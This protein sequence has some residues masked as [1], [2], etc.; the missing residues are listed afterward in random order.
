MDVPP[1]LWPATVTRRGSPPNV[2]ML[3]RTHCSAACWSRRPVAEGIGGGGGGNTSCC[4]CGGGR[5]MDDG[6]GGFV[7]VL[8]LDAFCR[9]HAGT[10][11]VIAH[12]TAILLQRCNSKPSKYIEPVVDRH[13]DATCTGA[14]MQGKRSLILE[15]PTA[16]HERPAVD[17]DENRQGGGG[18]GEG[19]GGGPDVEVKTVFAAPTA[20]HASQ[21]ATQASDM[22]APRLHARVSVSRGV[23]NTRPRLRRLRRRETQ[24]GDRRRCEGDALPHCH[25]LCQW[26]EV[27]HSYTRN[28]LSTT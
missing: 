28:L 9:V 21:A 18:G 26:R 1:L 27:G 11:T 2:A 13:H 17:V 22:H 5:V 6:S 3:S 4:A 25:R 20:A 10:H 19:L 16:R 15:L 23:V 14:C 8:A 24:A 7:I 12:R